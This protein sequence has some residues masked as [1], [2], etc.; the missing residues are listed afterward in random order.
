MC[1]EW[2]YDVKGA[3][4]YNLFFLL[5]GK[6]FWKEFVFSFPVFLLVCLQGFSGS[7]S[8][9]PQILQSN[10]NTAEITSSVNQSRSKNWSIISQDDEKHDKIIFFYHSPD[11]GELQDDEFLHLIRSSLHHLWVLYFC[12]PKPGS[13]LQHN[14]FVLYIQANQVL[15][16]QIIFSYYVYVTCDIHVISILGIEI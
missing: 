15:G 12:T 8:H 3:M 11:P 7:S 14:F 6:F 16:D 5:W 1:V 4:K 2:L 13:L 10:H 9:S